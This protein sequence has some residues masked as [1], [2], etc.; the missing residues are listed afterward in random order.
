MYLGL[1]P[2]N[3]LGRAKESTSTKEVVELDFNEHSLSLAVTKIHMNHLCVRTILT[4][5]VE[6]L[7]YISKPDKEISAVCMFQL[8]VRQ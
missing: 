5:A 3:D 4:R 7:R 6:M 8:L 2:G 1:V